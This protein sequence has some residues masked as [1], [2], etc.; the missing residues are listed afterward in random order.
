MYQHF[1]FFSI[2]F[3][4]HDLIK[5]ILQFILAY[6]L[7]IRST[8]LFSVFFSWVRVEH[9]KFPMFQ[10]WAL[11][12]NLTSRRLDWLQTAGTPA[13]CCKVARRARQ[14]C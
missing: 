1:S 13:D 14:A 7:K 5:F 9:T 3:K 12:H 2:I 10:Q 8:Y 11:K 4:K 6:M